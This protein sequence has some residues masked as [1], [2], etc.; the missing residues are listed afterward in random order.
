MKIFVGTLSTVLK[1]IVFCE[2][3]YSIFV[4]EHISKLG[5]FSKQEV[6]GLQIFIYFILSYFIK[7]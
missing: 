4:D 2:S 1:G 7:I 5:M 3:G 6:P